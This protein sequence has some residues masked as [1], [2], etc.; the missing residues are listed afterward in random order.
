[1]TNQF[2]EASFYLLRELIYSLNI[3]QILSYDVLLNL[4]IE[5]ERRNFEEHVFITD[6]IKDTFKTNDARFTT[7]LRQQGLLTEFQLAEIDVLNK[8]YMTYFSHLH[9]QS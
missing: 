2:D 3:S 1:M 4:L 5:I 8:T 9:C 6:F 7:L